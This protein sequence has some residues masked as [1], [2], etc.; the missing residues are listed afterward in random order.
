MAKNPYSV[1]NV[2]SSASADEI[3]AAYRKLAKKYHP[4]LNPGNKQAE[5]T[6]KEINA[7]NDIIGDPEKRA[8]FDRGEI[9]ETGTEKQR[10]FEG[11]SRPG[12]RPFY[13]ETQQGGG[14][15]TS[16]FEGMDD[17]FFARI[18]GGRADIMEDQA[19]DEHYALEIDFKSA[20]LGDEKSMTLPTGK[21]VKV[22]IPPG[23]EE[24]RRLRLRGLAE[25]KKRDGE[26][27][28][29]YIEIKIAPS[30]IF[31]RLGKDIELIAP[32]TYYEAICGAEIEV[33]TL[34]GRIKVKIP[35]G[36]NETTRLK[37]K[38]K[39]AGAANDS[40]RGDMYLRLQVTVPPKVDQALIDEMKQI[41]NR[42]PYSPRNFFGGR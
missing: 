10:P 34:E 36:S 38:G 11:Q 40:D 24:G 6:F 23:V 30:P 8:K 27:G 42:Y 33:P 15:Y 14:R 21:T 39:G 1:L 19:S 2:A 20:L 37:I 35:A 26:H 12:G 4:D 28:D 22:K 32:V 7:A 41:A 3:R 29:V 17:D 5:H 16:Q 13:Y 25:Q 18:F 31:K 9:D